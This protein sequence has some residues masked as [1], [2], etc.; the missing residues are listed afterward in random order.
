MI[1]H[2]RNT[3]I[4]GNALDVLKTFPDKSIPL[5]VTSPPYNLDKEYDTYKDKMNWGDF[6]SWLMGIRREL[7][8]V[9]ENVVLII[10]SHNGFEFLSRLREHPLGEQRTIVLPTW[11]IVNPVEVAV[12]E[13]SNRNRW[14]KKHRLPIVCNGAIATYLPCIVGNVKGQMLYGDHPCTFPERFPEAFIQS[15][16]KEGDIILDPFSGT[17]TTAVVAKKLN[18]D[19]IGIEISSKYVEVGRK[20]LEAAEKGISVKELEHGQ[21]SLFGE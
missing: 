13:F 2:L 7:H 15:L 8:R 6:M 17:A 5:V 21:G 9:S 11:S 12:Y 14:S 18:R 19:F 3:V 20:R 1:D 4:Q 10:G 16:S